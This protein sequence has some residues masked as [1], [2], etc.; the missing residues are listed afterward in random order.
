MKIIY[1]LNSIQHE[2]GIAKIT[3][4][5]AN[6]LANSGLYEV[7]VIVSDYDKRK[8][9][10]LNSNV[11][12]IDL[13]INYYIDDW[14]SKFNVLKGIIVKRRRHKLALQKVLNEIQPDIVVSVGQSEKYFLPEINGKWKTIREFHYD[15]FYRL[16]RADNFFKM[17]FAKLI[18]FYDYNFKIKNYDHIVLLTESDRKNWPSKMKIS[19]IPN[20]L[21][22]M[23]LQKSKLEKNIILAV[24]R[25][26]KQKNFS[27]LIRLFSKVVKKHP[28]WILEIY[29]SGSEKNKLIEDIKRYHLVNNVFL[30]GSVKDITTVLIDSSM[31]VVTSQYEGFGVMIIEAM[32]CGL[33]VISYDCPCGPSDII[34][35]EENG[36]LV[37]VNDEETFAERICRLITDKKLREEMGNKAMIRSQAYKEALI[38]NM[39]SNLFERLG[40]SVRFNH[41]TL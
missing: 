6:Y 8:M 41:K 7:Y 23:P 20:F 35:D 18:N 14:K 27:S 1:C 25:L 34:Q 16:H 4:A 17:I 21:P 19:V 5:K 24:G 36:F 30:K 12:L 10:G 11:R 38:L 39:W 9:T 2:G 22:S 26:E 31:L 3:Q 40:Q 29:G 13:D 28:D 33:P 15:K 32:S 37:P